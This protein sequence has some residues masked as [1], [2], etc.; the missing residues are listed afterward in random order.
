MSTLA[1][2]KEII[3]TTKPLQLLCLED[4]LHDRE[5]LE[6]EFRSAGLTCN[7]HH[8]MSREEFEAALQQ[9][10]F[11]LIISD[12]SLPQFDGLAAL[13]IAQKIQSDTPYIFFSGP[14][15]KNGQSKASRTVRPTTSSKIDTNAWPRLLNAL[16]SNGGNGWS[17]VN[18]KSNCANHRRWMPSASWQAASR[19]T[20]TTC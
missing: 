5:L 18:W 7:Y 9:Q 13:A 15:A 2:D 16:C 3:P 1:T 6:A 20:S 17:A 14:S 11:D 12:F 10:N 4:N 19:T 8:V